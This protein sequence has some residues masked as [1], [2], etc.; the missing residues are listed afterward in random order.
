[1]VTKSE[2]SPYKVDVAGSTP[3][4]PTIPTDEKSA[5]V[6]EVPQGYESVPALEW[7]G[8]RPRFTRVFK[9][10]TPNECDSG[11]TGRKPLRR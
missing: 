10:I 8:D 11:V 3:A 6:V 9:K 4:A 1:M 5:Q 2:A 7:E